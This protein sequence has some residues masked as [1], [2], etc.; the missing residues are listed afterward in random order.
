MQSFFEMLRDWRWQ[1]A[2]DG[3]VTGNPHV[4]C[5]PCMLYNLLEEPVDKQIDTQGQQLSC[6]RVPC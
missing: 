5:C 1:G 4:R 6:D 2:P 3:R